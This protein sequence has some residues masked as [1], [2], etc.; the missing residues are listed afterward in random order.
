MEIIVF[1][2]ATWPVVRTY[3]LMMLIDYHDRVESCEEM[4][5]WKRLNGVNHDRCWTMYGESIMT[6]Y[7][8]I[9]MMYESIG[10]WCDVIVIIIVSLTSYCFDFLLSSSLS[11]C[12]LSI[13]SLIDRWIILHLHCYYVR[14][15]DDH[16]AL[17]LWLC[18]LRYRDETRIDAVKIHWRMEY[19]IGK[20]IQ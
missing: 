9:M 4:S 1:M 17:M 20:R 3:Q 6:R 19:K 10:L 18:A 2:S 13:S 11:S 16:R 12:A 14:F 7:V 8:R 5:E 15:N